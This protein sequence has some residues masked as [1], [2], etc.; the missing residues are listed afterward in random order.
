MN[1]SDKIVTIIPLDTI[2]T[3]ESELK[4]KRGRYLTADNIK[5]LLRQGQV[6]FM[7]ADVG[8]KPTWIDRT[9]CFNFWKLEVEKHLVTDINKI[10][11]DNF[12]D[13]YAYVASEWT[14]DGSTP[15]ILLEKMH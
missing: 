11:I 12:R 1:F 3:S 4:S 13:S 2:W 7:I 6:N 15:I 14:V 5:D 9:Q 8:Q 10:Y